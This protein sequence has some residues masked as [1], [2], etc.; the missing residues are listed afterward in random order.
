MNKSTS[1]YLDFLRVIAAFGVL[2]VHANFPW[3]SNHLFFSDRG[4]GNKFVMVFFVLSGYLIAFTVKE[5]NK[6]SQKYLVDRLS[7]LYSVI[8]PAL[9][10]TFIFDSVGTHFN[11]EFYLDKMKSDH[12]AFRYLMN[13]AN[14]SQI[15]GFC[16]YPSTN[17]PFWSLSY[18]F[19]YYMIFW[20]WVYLEGRKRILGL[21]IIF[22]I[23]GV[24]I[25]LLFPVWIFGAVAYYMSKR[26]TFIAKFS[27]FLF[28]ATLILIF[29]LTFIWDFSFFSDKF[30]YGEQPLYFSSCF[31]FDWIYGALIAFNIFCFSYMPVLIKMPTI[32]EKSV[33]YL[34]SITFS[35]YLYHIPMLVLIAALVSYNKNSYFQIVLIL[36]GLIFVV[37]LLSGI[38][39]KRR[40]YFKALIEKVFLLLSRRKKINKF[41]G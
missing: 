17:G 32:I 41:N 21:I 34:S 14:L 31:I 5:K 35:L 26:K 11:P 19:W 15:W 39:E 23:I 13:I 29:I 33:K 25:L 7:R 28:F 3:F 22:C 36:F 2:L 10:L 30:I 24:K 1:I 18:E 16:T 8:L 6:G 20:A 38:T 37:S 9:L 27:V 40:G 12:Q 4:L